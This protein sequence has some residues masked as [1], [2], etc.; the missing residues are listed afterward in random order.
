MTA[1]TFD[2]LKKGAGVTLSNGNLTAL[3]VGNSAVLSV[4]AVDDVTFTII[5]GNDFAV[6][7]H[8]GGGAFGAMPG[9]DGGLSLALYKNGYLYCNSVHVPGLP[10]VQFDVGDTI[11]AHRYGD[12]LDIHKNNSATPSLSYTGPLVSGKVFMCTG[13]FDQGNATITAD[14]VAVVPAPTTAPTPEPT[15][16]PS[17]SPTPAPSPTPSP[18]PTPAP[19]PT[20]CPAPWVCTGWVAAALANDSFVHVPAGAQDIVGTL[21]IR[22]GQAWFFENGRITHTGPDPLFWSIAAGWTVNGNLRCQGATSNTFMLLQNAFAFTVGSGARAIGFGCGL[23]VQDSAYHLGQ[24][25]RGDRGKFEDLVLRG[26]VQGIDSNAAAEYM[27]FCNTNVIGCQE[28]I[29]VSGGNN[30]FV[31]GNVV[32]NVVGVKLRPGYNNGHGGFHGVNINHNGVNVE[33]EGI[34]NGHTFNGCHFYG[35]GPTLGKV[36]IKDSLGVSLSGGQLD[37][38]V[39]HEGT[40]AS[41]LLGNIMT[42]ALFA[43]TG[44]VVKQGN[45][46]RDGTPA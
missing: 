20:S 26:C 13:S 31:G 3:C 8:N 14:F 17:P 38:S 37:C 5:S 30:Q 45:F 43:T 12:T 18:S 27:Q 15:P 24:V 39:V 9:W 41:F 6:G 2:P 16:S 22:A 21:E 28:A 7:V 11:R 46:Y 4:D 23:K 1:T 35:D 10:V 42:G 36:H 25:D 34:T 40:G 19:G 33:A 29:A 32:D 44:N